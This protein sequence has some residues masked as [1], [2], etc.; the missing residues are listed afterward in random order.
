MNFLSYRTAN[1]KTE[2]NCGPTC[3]NSPCFVSYFFFWLNVYQRLEGLDQT[4]FFIHWWFR[5]SC[6]MFVE[7]D[8]FP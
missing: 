6:L 7:P 3:I 5:I 2:Q 8:S 4:I 1:T